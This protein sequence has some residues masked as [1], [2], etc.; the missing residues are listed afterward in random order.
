M[1]KQLT[2]TPTASIIV[3][4]LLISGEGGGGGGGRVMRWCDGL[5]KLT[6]PTNLD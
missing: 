6:V 4:A 3:L 5:G 2:P 1:S